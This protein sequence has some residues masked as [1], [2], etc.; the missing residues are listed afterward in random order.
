MVYNVSAGKHTVSLQK[1]GF[2]VEPASATVEVAANRNVPVSFNLVAQPTGLSIS[3]AVRGTQVFLGGK[4]VGTVGR[5]GSFQLADVTPG[6]QTIELRKRGWKSKAVKLAIQA[7]QPA[8]LAPP[9][10]VL[11]RIEGT[12]RFVQREPKSGIAARIDP[13]ANV[14]EYDGPREVNQVPAELKLPAGTYNITFSANGYAPDTYTIVV[15]DGDS[16]PIDIPLKKH[17]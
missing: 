6:P 2:K 16:K 12:L 10:S 15:G 4:L 13:T 11:P 9:D 17:R 1:P 14:I 8:A 3:G 5:D 7:G